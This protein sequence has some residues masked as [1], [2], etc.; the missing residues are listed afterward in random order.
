VTGSAGNVNVAGQQNILG[1]IING[2]QR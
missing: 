1:Q 2:Q